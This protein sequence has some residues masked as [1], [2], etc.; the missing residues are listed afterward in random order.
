MDNYPNMPGF[1]PGSPET[2]QQ[3]A[4]SVAQAAISREAMALALIRAN[5]ANGCTADEVANTYEW[6]RYSSR[7]RLSGLKAQGKIVDSGKRRK[8]V[9]GRSQAV[10]VLPEYGPPPP[11]D[12]QGDLLKDAA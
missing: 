4:E 11:P 1:R 5:A 3:A 12:A 10:W 2:S 8:A 7:P 6:E 9:S